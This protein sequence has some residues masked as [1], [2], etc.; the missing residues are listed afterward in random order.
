MM[1]E[2]KKV[3]SQWCDGDSDGNKKRK[4]F[5]GVEDNEVCRANPTQPLGFK[6]LPGWFFG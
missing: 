3:A 1:E 2:I 4:V 5:N 6:S